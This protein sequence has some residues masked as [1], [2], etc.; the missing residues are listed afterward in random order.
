LT[1]ERILAW[2][3]APPRSHRAVANAAVGPRARSRARDLGRDRLGLAPGPAIPA[4]RVE[5]AASR[6]VRNIHT[7]PR[8]TLDQVLAWAD[9]YQAKTGRWPRSRLGQIAD[10][11][12][13]T[14]SVVE[15]ALY[16]GLR[17]LPGGMTLSQLLTER[18]GAPA[19]EAQP[20]T[21][22]VQDTTQ[23]L[24]FSHARARIRSRRRPPR[25]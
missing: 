18:R 1:Y 14:W 3:D 25:V 13:E 5:L 19:I 17:G 6:A 20:S 12:G 24:R 9:A 16:Q 11:P 8:L 10:A 21:D 15:T 7:L 2:A 23:P 4:W 22:T